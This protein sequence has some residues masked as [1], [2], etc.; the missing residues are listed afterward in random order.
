M[1]QTLI[2][3]REV[4]ELLN[5]DTRTVQ[6]RADNGDLPF[7][8]KMPGLRGAYILDRNQIASTTSPSSVRPSSGADEG[9][10]SSS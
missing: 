4:A 2:S 9:D 5:V 6:R 8:S 10:S 1:V 3:S 7:V